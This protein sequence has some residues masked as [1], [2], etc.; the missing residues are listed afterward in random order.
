MLVA[1]LLCSASFI[2]VCC[3][4]LY[5]SEKLQH[6]PLLAETGTSQSW[7]LEDLTRCTRLIFTNP[8]STLSLKLTMWS[9][10]RNGEVPV[11]L[12]HGILL[13]LLHEVSSGN[14]RSTGCCA[15]SFFVCTICTCTCTCS[16]LNLRVY[17]CRCQSKKW[18]LFQSW[19]WQYS[20]GH[21]HNVWVSFFAV[22][23]LEQS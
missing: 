11:H 2:S 8:T 18:I 16:F 17:H 12:D 9:L 7:V 15:K 23:C 1:L 13:I 4:L 3:Y 21:T 22:S 6:S 10:I 19:N 20:Y 14:S 5:I